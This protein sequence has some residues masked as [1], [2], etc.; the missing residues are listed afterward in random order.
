MNFDEHVADYQSSTLSWR[1]G[2]NFSDRV[3]LVIY[4]QSKLLA[5]SP[6]HIQDA[7]GGRGGRDER[8]RPVLRARQKRNTVP[9]SRRVGIFPT[10][11]SDNYALLRN[12][13]LAGRNESARAVKCVS[14]G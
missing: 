1:V 2:L 6:L 10:R 7:M 3:A 9:Y 14:N 4:A 12:G 5:G 11:V 8:H 13:I